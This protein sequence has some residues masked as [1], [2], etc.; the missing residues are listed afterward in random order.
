MDAERAVATLT[1]ARWERLKD[2]FSQARELDPSARERFVAEACGGD[3]S[4]ERTLA[5]MLL[6][7]NSSPGADGPGLTQEWMAGILLAEL[8]MFAPG[9]IVGQ[10]FR[11]EAFIAEGGMGEVYAAEDLELG[12]R[13][14]LKTIRPEFASNERILTQ[15]KREIQLA[16]K[17]THRNVCR[18]FDFDFH[19]I[20]RLAG[21]RS[22]MFLSM[23]LLQGETLAARI[24]RTGPLSAN[25]AQRIVLQ[26]IEGLD[27]AHRAGIIHRDFKSANVVLVP[28]G[29]DER[30]V[31]MDFGLAATF[32]SAPGARD[33]LIG[34]PAYMA[35]EQV[36]NLPLTFATDLY[37]LGVVMFE[38]ISGRLPFQGAT[39]LETA[40]ARLHQE[41]PSL[42][43]VAPAAPAAWDRAVRACL[44]REPANRPASASELKARL[45]GRYEWRRRR[46]FLGA[47]LSVVIAAAGGWYWTQRPYQPVPAAQAA[48]DSARVKLQNITEAGFREAILDYKQAIKLDPAW[49]Q[50]WA[51]LAYAY[52]T[53]ANAQYMS[54][55]TARVEART[56]ALRAIELDGRSSRAYGAL[57]WVQS[58][59]FD[60]WPS[61]EETLRRAVTLDPED[62]RIRYWL[63]VHL[64]KKGHFAKAE[65][66]TQ[67]AMDLTRQTDAVYW[68]ELA[69]LYWT[70]GRLDRMEKLMTELL[71]A[72]PNFGFSRY[73]HARLLKE[74]GRFDEALA[75]LDFSERLQFSSVTALAERASIEAWRGNHEGA[76]AALEKLT[77]IARTQPVDTLL[78][79]GVHAKLG[80]RD[81]AL[82]W[83]ERG[84]KQR[85]N[86]LL[87]IAT[88]PLL[89]PL[90]GEPRFA[91]LCRRLHFDPAR[92]AAAP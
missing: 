45:T 37:A 26:L 57:G 84:F 32:G 30:A 10:R 81:A 28:D 34:T 2:L 16:R 56:A 29:E 79:A 22:V 72:H 86:T 40:R 21:P 80:D 36:E 88:S 8:R 4:L 43:S 17:V 89:K 66:Q 70:A 65:Q 60:E 92:L 38:M 55:A 46:R 35:P 73:L 18:I 14:A 54:P 63:G 49:A 48:V 53:R 3:R 5:A 71:V 1:Q 69:F 24:R 41:A 6:H 23:E 75:E 9:E 42:R 64:R 68:C 78:I 85:D 27:A 39:P 12:E 50:P 82:S 20:D 74:R 83:L 90:H 51:E 44:Q 58:L 61:A 15:F 13:L 77:E 47:A 62:A 31:I 52:A 59:D 19:Q 7:D 87:S 11:I 67:R 91:T 25:D 76:R 33:G